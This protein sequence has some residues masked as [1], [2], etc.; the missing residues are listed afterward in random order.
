MCASHVFLLNFVPI[1]TEKETAGV[2]CS[3]RI[4]GP[5]GSSVLIASRESP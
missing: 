5:H 4:V 2:I 1:Q 3:P